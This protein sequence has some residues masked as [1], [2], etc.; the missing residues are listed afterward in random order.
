MRRRTFIPCSP[1]P[2]EERITPSHGG[3]SS[4][5]T[6]THVSPA[7]SAQTLNLYG[8]ILGSDKVDGTVHQLNSSSAS[9]SPSGDSLVD[10]ALDYSPQ[11]RSKPTGSRYR[12][13][14]K[15]TGIDH[16]L[17]SRYGDCQQRP[18]FFRLPVT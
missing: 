2:L 1:N 15:R 17:S 11:G 9:L 8:F 12:D 16:G 10:R 14:L 3:L 5:A 4:A 13:D 6:S 7:A 18:L